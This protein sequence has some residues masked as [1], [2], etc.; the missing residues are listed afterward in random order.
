MAEV[1]R[2]IQFLWPTKLD[3][4]A[5]LGNLDP[6]PPIVSSSTQLEITSLAPERDSS[7]LAVERQ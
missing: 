1:R 4:T 2:P 3:L 7:T 5:K 6:L